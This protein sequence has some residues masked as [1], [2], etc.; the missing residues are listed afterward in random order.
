MSTSEIGIFALHSKTKR[1]RFY[2]V[3]KTYGVS[4]RRDDEE[5]SRDVCCDECTAQVCTECWECVGGL[6]SSLPPPALTN[7]MVIHY[8]PTILY[9]KSVTV[10][11]MICASVCITSMICFTLEKKYRNI[12]SFDEEVHGNSRRMACRGNGT[13]FPLPWHD[14]LVQLKSS[15]HAASTNQGLS[16]PRVGA[17]LANVVSILLK[18]CRQ[19]VRRESICDICSSG[20]RSSERCHRSH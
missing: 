17:D 5:H 15:E 16:L 12:L 1:L 4:L 3:R 18:H 14:L 8:A 19:G 10:M 20:A 6:S 13:S 2:V 11:E 9:S 7:D